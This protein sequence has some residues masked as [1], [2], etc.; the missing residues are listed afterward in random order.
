METNW[1]L[2][3]LGGV[4]AEYAGAKKL[5]SWMRHP[6]A[7]WELQ[8]MWLYSPAVRALE[9]G[10]VSPLIF[11]CDI[12]GEFGLDVHPDV[13]LKQFPDFVT[14]F[15]PGTEN[16]LE[17]LAARYSLALLSNTNQPQW[18]RLGGLSN[19]S[20][21]FKELFLSFKT[22]Y[23]KPDAEAFLNV[24]QTLRCAP[25]DILFFD[26]QPDNVRAAL[27][28]GMRAECVEGFENLCEKVQE[29]GLI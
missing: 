5:L 22:G 4:L 11:A 1:L 6:V 28:A 12:I 21:L 7:E 2:F 25:G 26:D 18:E 24:L 19:P 23:L 27:D 14:G 20:R 10:R 3:D 8:R 13:F 15:Y 29:L 9:S 17:K 16:L